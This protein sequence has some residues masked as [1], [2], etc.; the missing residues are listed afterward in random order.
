M[1][2]MQFWQ[3]LVVLISI[4][5][6]MV[7]PT[8]WFYR[9]N[10][11]RIEADS[12]AMVAKLEQA[13]AQ[14]F[15]NIRDDLKDF[16]GHFDARFGEVYIAVDSKNREMKELMT[17]ELEFIRKHISGIENKIEDTRERSHTLEKDLLR[18]QATLGKDYITRDDLQ[19]FI[20]SHSDR[21]L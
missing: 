12:K 11:T 18:L 3:I 8:I 14:A 6:A 10:N 16:R 15:S 17:K 7:A 2:H 19:H 13:N 20:L 21:G 9:H 4:A 5:G 1:E